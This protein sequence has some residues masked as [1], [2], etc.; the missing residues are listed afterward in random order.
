MLV[1]YS[2]PSIFFYIYYFLNLLLLLFFFFFF[3]DTATTEIYTLSLHDA[4]PIRP[5]AASVPPALSV[6]MM[7]R[8]ISPVPRAQVV[9]SGQARTCS[10][11]ASK[12]RIR[13]LFWPL[14]EVTSRASRVP[15]YLAMRSARSLAPA[16]SSA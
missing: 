13:P 8:A 7:L 10:R 11:S 9:V 3:N 15:T 6:V 4:L 2:H 14:A 5:V 12:L 1:P 16:H